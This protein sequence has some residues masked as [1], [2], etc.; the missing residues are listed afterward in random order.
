MQRTRSHFALVHNDDESVAGIVT[1]DD[2]LE[3]LLGDLTDELAG[4][5]D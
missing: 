4:E 3:E 5:A 2:L 1:L